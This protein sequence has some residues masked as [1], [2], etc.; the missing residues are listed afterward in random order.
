MVNFVNGRGE[1]GREEKITKKTIIITIR[2]WVVE[3][4]FWKT[5]EIRNAKVEMSR[6]FITKKME[7][8]TFA[9]SHT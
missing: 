9:Q 6:K 8:S 7:E 4:S 3:K 5:T 1:C 2:A